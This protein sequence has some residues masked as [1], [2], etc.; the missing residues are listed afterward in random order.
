MVTVKSLAG[1]HGLA[2]V[3]VAT[4]HVNCAPAAVER[5]APLN[6]NAA[7]L[8]CATSVT[9]ALPLLSLKVTVMAKGALLSSW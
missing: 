3:R 6:D 1:T 5:Y 2:S 8:T 9:V 4:W 7:S